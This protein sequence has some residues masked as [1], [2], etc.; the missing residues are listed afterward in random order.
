MK[1][2]KK[3]CE[4]LRNTLV[5]LKP[6]WLNGKSCSWLSLLGGLKP[7]EN[8]DQCV[9]LWKCTTCGIKARYFPVVRATLAITIDKVPA[10][11]VASPKLPYPLPGSGRR[12][13]TLA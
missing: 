12:A 5:W 10:T 11:H 9:G 6:F 3:Q 7:S 4:R 13:E 8:M 1:E 2:G